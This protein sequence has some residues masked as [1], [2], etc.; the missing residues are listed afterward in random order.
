MYCWTPGWKQQTSWSAA[1]M[2]VCVV[3]A[4]RF[5]RAHQFTPVVLFVVCVNN[6]G[7]NQYYFSLTTHLWSLRTSNSGLWYITLRARAPYLVACWSM[8]PCLAINGIRNAWCLWRYRLLAG[9]PL[10]QL[11]F[12]WLQYA[13][14]HHINCHRQLRI[15][16]NRAF[17]WYNTEVLM[18]QRPLK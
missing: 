14:L 2:V 16:Q 12:S 13:L 10:P 17:G 18:V 5:W 9:W 8:Q 7:A 1:A 3:S 11:V 4:D 6:I 15:E